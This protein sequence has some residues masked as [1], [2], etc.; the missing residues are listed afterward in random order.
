MM[1]RGSNKLPGEYPKRSA[2]S[3]KENVTVWVKSLQKPLDKST[4]VWYNKGVK[5]RER[6][7]LPKTSQEKKCKKPLDKP[8]KV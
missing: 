8:L 2:E 4:K 7:L 1:S 3:P 6:G 5:R